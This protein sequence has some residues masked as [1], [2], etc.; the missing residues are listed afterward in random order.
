VIR[1]GC[2]SATSAHITSAIDV[3][4]QV[5][6]AAGAHTV[7]VPIAGHRTL[8]KARRSRGCES[9]S[10]KCVGFI[11][12]GTTPARHSAEGRERASSVS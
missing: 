12:R 1:T 3:L 4:A 8:R 9:A 7:H 5:S 11:Y 2:R 6:S 10:V